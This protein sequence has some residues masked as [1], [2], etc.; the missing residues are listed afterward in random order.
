MPV[1]FDNARV[2]TPLAAREGQTVITGAEGKI[3]YA[4][5]MEGAPRVDGRRYDLRGRILAPGLIDI[6]RHGGIGINFGPGKNVAEEL[7]RF[8]NWVG[9]EGISGFLCSIAAP[10]EP[11]LL[12]A[13]KE[14]VA[15]FKQWDSGAEP[16]GLHLEGPYLNREE[17]RGAFNPEWLR[18]PSLEET[19]RLVA[20]G[21]GWIRQMTMDPTLPGADAVSGY[22]RQAGVVVAMGHTNAIY[23]EAMQALETHYTHVTHTFNCLRG[24]HHREPGAAGAVLASKGVSAELISDTY[25]VHPGAMKVLIRCLGVDRVILITDA[26]AGSGM[27]DGEFDLLGL[28]AIVKDG[29][30]KLKDGTIAGCTTSFN[31]CL[32]IVMEQVEVPLLQAVQMATLNP[33][34]AMGFAH[35]LGSIAPGKDAS[36]VVIDEDVHVFLTMVKGEVVY[37][38]W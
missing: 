20:A 21:E 7:T 14:Y 10:N 23:S 16:L 31:R 5:P 12:G 8:A 33:A 1:I 13:V 19:K 25:H 26:I 28:P 24:V 15:A 4:G 35:R 36:L 32:E 11:A 9:C 38:D 22:L 3:E 30:A 29:E 18:D 6:H 34:H 17:K 27:P 37:E 2:F